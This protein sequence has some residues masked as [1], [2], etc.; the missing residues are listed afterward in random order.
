MGA[1]KGREGGAVR[2]AQAAAAHGR[3]GAVREE[4]DARVVVVVRADVGQVDGEV[5]VGD[6]VALAGLDD[7]GDALG[8]DDV[9]LSR[10]RL[11]VSGDAT[12][13]DLGRLHSLSAQEVVQRISWTSVMSKTRRRRY[14][15]DSSLRS[16]TSWRLNM[17]FMVIWGRAAMRSREI[18]GSA[19]GGPVNSGFMLAGQGA[20][21]SLPDGLEELDATDS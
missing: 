6:G 15:P 5:E 7:A 8:R 18:A 19:L 13:L 2:P 12:E 16:H 9:H 21:S 3:L 11:L 1:G 17:V 14:S 4:S 10:C 20:G